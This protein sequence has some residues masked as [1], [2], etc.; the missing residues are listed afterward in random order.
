MGQFNLPKLIVI[1]AI[2]GITVGSL[3]HFA[4]TMCTSATCQA[5]FG[6]T[7]LSGMVVGLMVPIGL[8]FSKKS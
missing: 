6:N 4:G 1:M 5:I 2:L 8:H 3:F 7:V